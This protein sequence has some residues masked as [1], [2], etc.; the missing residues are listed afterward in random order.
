MQPFYRVEASNCNG[1]LSCNTG[2]TGKASYV[3]RKESLA[4]NLRIF[5]NAESCRS[6][7]QTRR[8]LPKFLASAG[9]VI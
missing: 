5:N 9:V 7:H 3:A 4:G 6:G 8:P 1:V 2:S